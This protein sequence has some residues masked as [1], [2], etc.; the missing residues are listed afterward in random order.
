[1]EQGVNVQ[2]EYKSNNIHQNV[3]DGQI[4]CQSDDN[5]RQDKDPWEDEPTMVQRQYEKKCER[6][7]Y[8]I[9]IFLRKASSTVASSM[10]ETKIKVSK[11]ST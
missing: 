1:M 11:S 4:I 5:H 7:R 10:S 6:T 3:F 9:E 8:R 2:N